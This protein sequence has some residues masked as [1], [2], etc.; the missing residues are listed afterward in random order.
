MLTKND[1]S[2]PGRAHRP[3]E[4]TYPG[5]GGRARS[6]AGRGRG[7]LPTGPRRFA[8]FDVDGAAEILEEVPP[9]LRGSLAEEFRA[10]VLA[11]QE[12]IAS[13]Q[14]ELRSAVRQNRFLDLPSKIERLL[15][16]KPDHAYGRKLAEK[17]QQ[18]LVEAAEKYLAEHQYDQALAPAGADCP[19][20]SHAAGG[21]T[22]PPGRGIGLAGL[23]PAQR[24]GGR[25][26]LDWR[27]PSGCGG[28]RPATRGPRSSRAELHRRS[29]LAESQGRAGR[30]LGRVRR[31]RRRWGF[32]SIGSRAFAASAAPRRC[33]SPIW[34]GRRAALPSPAVWL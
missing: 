7:G 24:P 17:V 31:S 22:A 6:T 14:Q 16:L 27:S 34:C 29:R 18:H 3:G 26:D 4:T 10:E 28:W 33:S 8:A 15:A 25:R 23:G 13:L 12:E 2:R 32:P 1:A 20:R 21:T 30:C 9:P 11:R 19:P 5:R